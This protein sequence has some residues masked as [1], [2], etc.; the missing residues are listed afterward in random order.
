MYVLVPALWILGLTAV[1]VLAQTGEITGTIRVTRHL[2]RKR[3]TLPQIYERGVALALPATAQGDIAEEMTRVVVYLEGAHGAEA[4]H[5]VMDQNHRRF[6][7]EV[8]A[9]PVGSTVDFPNS[10]PI[11]HNVFSLSRARPFDLG[12]YPQGTSRSLRFDQPG[13]VV[14]NCHLH[15]NMTGVV[16]VTPNRY[17]ARPDA[18]G[19]FSIP[20]LRPGKYHIV[21]W[22]KSAGKIQK[23]FGLEA[24]KTAE[25]DFEIPLTETNSQ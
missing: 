2:T 7:P 23:R 24:G 18:S 4:V 6:E 14:L 25:V 1:P 12:N 17:F 5:A 10:D 16:V 22:H 3:I 13:I 19:R 9:V 8:L 21:A 15:P 11:Y 20:G